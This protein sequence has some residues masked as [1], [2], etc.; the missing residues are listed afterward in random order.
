MQNLAIDIKGLCAQASCYLPDDQVKRVQKAYRYAAKLHRGQQRRSGDPYITHPLAVAKILADMHL[1]SSSIIAAILHD[2]IEDTHAD[3]S[4][5]E[6]YFG[7]TVAKLVDGVS[8]LE[9]LDNVAVKDKQSHNLHKVAMASA[10]DVR[11]ILVKLADRLHN[12]RTIGCMPYKAQQRIGRETLYFYAPIA[13]RLGLND[14]CAELEDLSFGAIYPL[15]HRCIASAVQSSMQNHREAIQHIAEQLEQ[16]LVRAKIKA[17]VS[18]RKKGLYSIYRKMRDTQRIFADIMDVFG[19]RIIV[20]NTDTCYLALGVVHNLYRPLDGQFEDFIATP[21]KNGYQSL[22]TVLFGMHGIRIEIQIRTHAMEEMA[23]KGLASH[24]FYKI[25]ERGNDL[26]HKRVQKWIT[27]LLDM[28]Q[29]KN[30]GEFM[31]HLREDLFAHHI[32]VY[33]PKGNIME[34]P[35]GS[36]PVD[37]AYAIHTDIG[38]RCVS[39]V[40][41]RR[42]VALNSLLENGQTVRIITSSEARPNPSWIQFVATPKARTQIRHYLREQKCEDAIALGR[43]LLQRSIAILGYDPKTVEVEKSK[44]FKAVSDVDS[45]DGLLASIGFGECNATLIAHKL[46]GE[47]NKPT[48]WSGIQK[49]IGI[50]SRY[51]PVYIKDTESMVVDFGHCCSPI[52]GDPIAGHAGTERG[53]VVHNRHCRYIAKAGYKDEIIALEWSEDVQ[54]EFN[55]RLNIQT[56]RARS[57]LAEIANLVNRLGASVEKLSFEERDTSGNTMVLSLGVHNRVHLARIIKAVRK[58]KYVIKANRLVNS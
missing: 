42:R 25:G 50:H 28:K 46:L 30:P 23:S 43:Q 9:Q 24:H 54:G 45:F 19:Y 38:N 15:R 58:L 2:V 41:N 56:E 6:K 53:L 8:H 21:K 13:H 49:R 4:S 12:M 47:D 32:Y 18:W 7:E 20:K 5:V 37:F 34:L 10:E 52:P 11:V 55:A 57:I 27:G 22:H 16:A 14:I 51:Q 35:K 40:V 26:Q 36:T 48:L 31:E 39:C 17:K 29:E 1:D 33:T 44:R 3:K